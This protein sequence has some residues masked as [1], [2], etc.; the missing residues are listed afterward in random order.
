MK[1]LNKTISKESKSSV[2][3]DRTER[4]MINNNHQYLLADFARLKYAFIK[5]QQYIYNKY[6]KHLNNK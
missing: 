5:L 2:I 4:L 6:F 1:I 3:L